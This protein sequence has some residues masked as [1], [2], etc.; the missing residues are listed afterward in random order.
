MNAEV[1]GRLRELKTTLETGARYRDGMLTSVAA[2]LESWQT[3][4]FREKTVYHT[5]NKLSVDVASKVLVAEVWVPTCSMLRVQES[6]NAA[7]TALAAQVWA[8][9][10][11]PCVA[12]NTVPCGRL[13]MDLAVLVD[14]SA[15]D[16][17]YGIITHGIT[18][19]PPGG[20]CLF[21]PPH[22]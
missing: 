10:L 17:L 4:V 5:L 11:I 16:A 18:S 12:T 3:Q 6:L 1:S 15:C 13:S 19:P 14:V 7:T 20:A 2:S 22:V 9:L 21:P 8:V